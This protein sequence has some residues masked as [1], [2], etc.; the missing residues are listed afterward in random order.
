M[1]LEAIERI[2]GE[3]TLLQ[4]ALSEGNGA[5]EVLKLYK[6]SVETEHNILLP[7]GGH[8][9]LPVM[10]SK[11]DKVIVGV[12]SNI[13]IESSIDDAIEHLKKYID[14]INAALKERTQILE[15]LRNRYNELASKI[16][17]IQFKSQSQR[18]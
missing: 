16:A 12:G 13:F 1:V 10:M 7:I 11:P 6:E 8:I 2:Y 18:G 9:Y 3:I 17:E 14:N 4:R 5:M 15:Q